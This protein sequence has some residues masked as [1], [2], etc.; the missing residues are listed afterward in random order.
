MEFMENVIKSIWKSV[1]EVNMKNSVKIVYD[2]CIYDFYWEK[3]L[4]FRLFLEF[5]IFYIYV[6]K[7]RVKVRNVLFIINELNCNFFKK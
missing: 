5:F 3:K 1:G 2:L 4:K 6:F 7:L